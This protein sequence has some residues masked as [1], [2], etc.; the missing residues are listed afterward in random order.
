MLDRSIKD[1]VG[2]WYQDARSMRTRMDATITT[3]GDRRRPWASSTE[4]VEARV[5]GVNRW[6]FSVR[7]QTKRSEGDER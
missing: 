1:V 5:T 2:S 4:V 7:I 3:I 6:A